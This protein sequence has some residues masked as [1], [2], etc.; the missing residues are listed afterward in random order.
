MTKGKKI[1]IIISSTIIL[2]ISVGLFFLHYFLS[3]FALPKIEIT[4]D[5]ISTD[6]DFINGLTI[7]QIKVD[8][9]GQDGVPA[10]YKVNYWTSCSIDHPK[11][12][13]P[14]P[15]DII[16]FDK[17]GNYWWTE[18]KVELEFI[19]K[20]YSRESLDSKNR[21]LWS[22]GL[23]RFPTCPLE[24]KK[25][26]WYFIRVGDPKVTGLFFIIDKEGKEHQYY[27]KSG[28]SPI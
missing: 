27:L 11:G 5:Y 25:E 8:S 7:E 16:Y 2:I 24:F 22:L 1:I 3:A 10:K 18:E 23:K 19:H 12:K 9:F 6:R 13:P 14:E 28:V 21:I 15:P 17:K 26:Q 20:G 4:T